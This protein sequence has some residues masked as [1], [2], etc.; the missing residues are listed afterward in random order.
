MKQLII[1]PTP[2]GNLSDISPS[3]TEALSLVDI[4]L[5]ESF[6]SPKRLYQHLGI[7]LPKLIRYW[8]KTE[9]F[10]V[11]DLEGLPGEIVG[12]VSDA[13]MPGIS[14]PGYCLVAAWHALGWP[15]RVVSGPSAVTM[16]VA[17]SGLPAEAFQFLGFLQ[18]GGQKK[19][20]RLES[21][22]SSGLTTVLYESPRRVVELCKLIEKVFGSEHLVCVAKELTK[23]FES[24]YQGKVSD[25][26]DELEKSE[27]KG[28]FVVVIGRVKSEPNWKKDA[29]VLKQYLSVG[30]VSSALAKIHGV[31][32]S[33]VYDFLL[34]N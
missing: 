26:I 33:K 34:E 21:V 14:D 17:G 3:I 23:R 7:P 5:C 24:Y 25:V 27:L 9:A 15:L 8:Q 32:R 18:G 11:Q 12:L 6:A 13:G 2:I 22:K 4:L 20:Q 29:G 19:I 31:S 10:I 30:D 28:E 16:A 1:I